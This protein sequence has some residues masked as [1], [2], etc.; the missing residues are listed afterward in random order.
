MQPHHSK[1]IEDW[2]SQ[3]QDIE[4]RGGRRVLRVHDRSNKSGAS[5][6]VN[7]HPALNFGANDYL[8]LARHPLVVERIVEVVEQVGWGSGASP[9]VSGRGP[10][11]EELEKKLSDFEEA[12]GALLFPT[13]YAANMAAVMTLVGHGDVI[14]GDRL[15][16]ASLIDGCQLSGA[17][18]Y[19]YRHSD[20]DHLETLL[21]RHREKFKRAILVTD[22]LFSMDGDLAPVR[23]LGELASRYDCAVLADEAHATGVYGSKGAGWCHESGCID[24]V[25]IRTGTISKSLGGLGGFLVGPDPLIQ[26]AI[27]R[28]RGFMFST[29][30]PQAIAAAASVAIDLVSAMEQERIELRMMSVELRRTLREQG[31]QVGEGDSP[32]IPVYIGDPN[33][34]MQ[35]A[36]SLFGHGCYVPAIR[37]PSVPVGKS[38]LRISLSVMHSRQ[39]IAKLGDCFM[40]LRQQSLNGDT[41]SPVAGWTG[42]E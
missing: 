34:T 23:G 16:H 10:I 30:M 35:L 8:N 3:L 33:K 7:G 14:F 42:N 13:G 32:I 12:E 31:W 9:L 20:M 4:D 39:D 25:L 28:G 26:L 24:Q 27:H 15:N 38:L 17:E 11:H 6:S 5:M 36:K 37:P 21:K 2:V 40:S 1:W 19:R 29:A 41:S 22:T 18:V